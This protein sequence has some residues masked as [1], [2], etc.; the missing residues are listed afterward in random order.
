MDDLLMDDLPMDFLEALDDMRADALAPF[1][2]RFGAD[3][4]LEA[5]PALDL[6]PAFEA[7]FEADFAVD[8]GVDFAAPFFDAVLAVERVLA[9]ARFAALGLALWDD[10]PA[11]LRDPALRR[12]AM[13]LSCPI[14]VRGARG[15]HPC[16]VHGE[17]KV[18]RKCFQ[19]G[20]KYCGQG[21]RD[22]EGPRP[23]YISGFI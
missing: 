13:I 9:V 14:R 22:A 4:D 2:P 1:A 21:P 23:L 10:L 17:R 16:A 8:L 18:W 5:G 3:L 11:D 6:E 12:C 7:G 20:A 15:I 19:R